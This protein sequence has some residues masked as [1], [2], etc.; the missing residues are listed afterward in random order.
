M[1]NTPRDEDAAHGAEFKIEETP[2]LHGVLRAQGAVS[3]PN[4]RDALR[5]LEQSRATT[6]T[7][8]TLV[9]DALD[10][11]RFGRGAVV[12]IARWIPR[13]GA[14]LDR[15][16]LVSTSNQLRTS[17]QALAACAPR[18]KVFCADTRESALSLLAVER[19]SLTG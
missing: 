11:T 3:L 10:V 18:V 17:V 8:V 1:N 19:L 5:S 9:I 12:E 2:L 4:I 15:V 13:N 14:G 6:P 7:L 16:I